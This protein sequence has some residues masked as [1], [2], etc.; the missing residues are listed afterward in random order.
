MAR[1]LII[2]DA[3]PESMRED[4][5]IGRIYTRHASFS[6]IVIDCW[7]KKLMILNGVQSWRHVVSHDVIMTLSA[8]T[9][10]TLLCVG[11]TSTLAGERCIYSRGNNY[12][13]DYLCNPGELRWRCNN[14]GGLSKHKFFT[15]LSFLVNHF[16]FFGS[17]LHWAHTRWPILTLVRH[18][19][20]GASNPHYGWEITPH[21]RQSKARF[22][23][24]FI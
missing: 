7:G 22:T 20:P 18:M 5:N 2:N 16:G 3:R 15:S 24:L 1:T 11:V 8:V 21:M 14:V 9:L 23:F 6:Q 12:I 17:Q 10:L 4:F 19:R 13:N